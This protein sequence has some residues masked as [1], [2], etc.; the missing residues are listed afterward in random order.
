[1]VVTGFAAGRPR[2]RSGELSR[3]IHGYNERS[4]TRSGMSRAT[5]IPLRWRPRLGSSG[6]AGTAS[7]RVPPAARLAPPAEMPPNESHPS[8][9]AE[10]LPVS[11]GSLARTLDRAGTGFFSAEE[12]KWATVTRTVPAAAFGYPCEKKN[13]LP[14]FFLPSA[15]R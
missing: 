10:K 3:I 12:K 6:N 2:Y 9:A 14:L 8:A 11:A 7:A 1:M 13:C 15:S 5:T 4:G